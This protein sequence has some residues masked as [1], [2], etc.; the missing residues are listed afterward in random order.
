MPSSKVPEPRVDLV[1]GLEH[2]VGTG[3]VLTDEESRERY[4]FDALGPAGLFGREQLMECR[5]DAVVRPASTLQVSQVVRLAK[6]QRVAVVPYGGGT[7]VMGA[8]IPL[9]GGIALDMRAMD[10][11]LEV[12]PSERLARVQP[13]VLLSDLDKE[14]ERHGLLLGHDPWSLPIATVGGAISTDSVGY[15]ASKYGSMGK[16]VQAMEAVLADGSIV[17]TRPLAQPSSGPSL[18]QLMVG[19]EGTMGV[20]T[21]ATVQ[22]FAQPERRAF[23]TLGFSSFEAGFPVVTRLFG[24]GLVPALVDLTEEEP[25]EFAQGFPCLLYL[26]FEGYA[27]EVAAQK[28]RALAE[29]LSGGGIDLGP[30]P[31]EDYWAHR[32]E[33]AERWREQVQPLRPVE[34]WARTQWR[35][36]D[37]LHLSLPV[38]QVMDY[39][40]GVKNI[41]A[42]H[43]LIIRE[44]AVW[45]GPGLFSVLLT[46]P[47]GDE[48]GRRS[49][50]ATVVDRLLRAALDMG[51]GIEYCHGIGSKLSPLAA[52][53]WGDALP[54]ARRLKW[55]VDPQYTL[56]PDKLGL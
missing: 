53:E 27:Q 56:N 2:I 17:R 31:T 28:E 18:H 43:G 29:G 23:A 34:R 52:D 51:G 19:T 45:T 49:M 48:R 47:Q 39:Y 14:A 5:V 11:I 36:G 22:L 9:R 13:G 38:G 10:R 16:Q 20:I 54:L 50:L 41:T 46:D 40:Q 26:G 42:E 32:H 33:P 35:W 24:L 30:G 7:G 55:A 12:L 44:A 4:S 25:G 15:R 21:E 8:V 3:N 1:S 37:Y 6:E